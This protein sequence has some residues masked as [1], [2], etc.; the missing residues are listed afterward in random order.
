MKKTITIGGTKICV[1]SIREKNKLAGLICGECYALHIDGCSMINT[2]TDVHVKGDSYILC[3]KDGV[4]DSVYIPNTLVYG[5][6]LIGRH[7]VLDDKTNEDMHTYVYNDIPS[8]RVGNVQIC[9]VDGRYSYSIFANVVDKDDIV[10]TMYTD[11]NGYSTLNLL[12][13]RPLVTDKESI[14]S[15]LVDFEDDNGGRYKLEI[16]YMSPELSLMVKTI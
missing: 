5:R 7:N 4:Y 15:E 2:A 11:D 16:N 10:C 8:A 13:R 3:S 1:R 9:I 14:I 6:S 12:D